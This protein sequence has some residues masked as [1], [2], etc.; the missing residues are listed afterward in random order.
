MDFQLAFDPEYFANNMY[1]WDALERRG[2]PITRD[3]HMVDM[4]ELSQD[5]RLAITSGDPE[6]IQQIV[7]LHGSTLEWQLTVSLTVF[8]KLVH[9]L[10]EHASED[11]RARI[12]SIVREE[13]RNMKDGDE[14]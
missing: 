2:T 1:I 13:L 3:I 12:F 11:Q 14:S 6:R 8:Q 9:V 5:E 4:S 10:V 7:D